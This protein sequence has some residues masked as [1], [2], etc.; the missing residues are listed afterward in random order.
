MDY[1]RGAGCSSEDGNGVGRF[2][3]MPRVTVVNETPELIFTV[4]G[5]ENKASY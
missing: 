1:M 5:W 3:V 4:A 2:Q